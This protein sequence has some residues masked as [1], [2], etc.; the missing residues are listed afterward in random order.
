MTDENL[1]DTGTTTGPLTQFIPV[2]P[3]PESNGRPINRIEYPRGCPIC[4][5]HGEQFS[6]PNKLSEHYRTA[7][8]HYAK[9]DIEAAA[10]AWREGRPVPPARKRQ[11]EP[12][13]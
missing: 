8:P 1:T 11:P 13:Q 3:E 4:R 2:T 10:R 7:H 5:E 12:K 6:G 9:K